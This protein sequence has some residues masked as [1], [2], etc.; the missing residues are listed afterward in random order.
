MVLHYITN[1]NFLYTVQLLNMFKYHEYSEAGVVAA[2]AFNAIL[3]LLSLY[4]VVHAG[5]HVKVL[6]SYLEHSK[7][8]FTIPPYLDFR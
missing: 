2:N 4:L 1:Y 5:R 3:G 6:V 8:S 7:W